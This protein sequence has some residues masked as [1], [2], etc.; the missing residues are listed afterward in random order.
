MIALVLGGGGSKAAFQVGAVKYLYQEQG[1]RPNLI[2]ACSGGSLNGAK[3]AEGGDDAPSRLE[4]IWRGLDKD[5][6]MWLTEPWLATL[7]PHLQKIALEAAAGALE[8]IGGILTFNPIL[9]LAG[10]ATL[11]VTAD[12]LNKLITALQSARSIYNLG[13]IETILRNPA[14]FD[15]NR[16][17]NSNID[18]RLAVVGLESGELRYVLKDGHVEG[19]NGTTVSLADAVLTSAS[20]PFVFPP[21]KIGPETY[22]D[23]GVREM[24]PIKTAVASGA[25]QIYAIPASKAGVRRHGSFDSLNVLD[26]TKRVAA[27][28]MPDE[29]Q[30][31]ETNPDGAGWPG[32][33]T[34]I[35]PRVETYDGLTIH[36]GLI[37]LAIDY[38]WMCARDVV[39]TTT[40]RNLCEQVTDRLLLLRKRILDIEEKGGGSSAG[41]WFRFRGMKRLVAK[42]ATLRMALGGS[43]P[44]GS[45]WWSR[46]E[47]HRRAWVRPMPTP[48]DAFQLRP[49]PEPAFVPAEDPPTVPTAAGLTT[50][51]YGSTVVLGHWL[52]DS[53]L[54]S[55]P[56]AY[57]HSGTSG[58]QRVFGLDESTGN[59][60]WI[61]K[62]PT[63]QPPG[64]RWGQPVQNGDVIRLEHGNTGRNLHSHAGFPS[65]STGQQ[66]V[67]CFGDHGTG[68]SNDDWRIEIEGGGPWGAGKRVRLIHVNTN[69]ALHSHERSFFGHN[70]HEDD[71]IPRPLQEVTAFSSRDDNDLWFMIQAAP[72]PQRSAVFV[73]QSVPA[74]LQA[75][76]RATVQVTL[77][78]TGSATWTSGGA[79]PFRLGSQN[80][81]ENQTWGLSRASLAA[82][83]VAPGAEATFTFEIQ[84]PAVPGTYNF[85]WRMLQH[86][87]EWFGDQTPN[88]AIQVVQ[89]PPQRSATFVRQTVPTRIMAGSSATVQITMRN[90][91]A[92]TWTSAV[93]TPFRL[94]SQN[95]QDNQRWGL[96]RV[97]LPVA[98][99][100]PGAEVTFSFDIQIPMTPGAFGFQWRMLQESVEWFGD[101]TANVTIR[102][103]PEGVG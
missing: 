77:R 99:V 49:Y 79:T 2:A 65:P 74:S 60:N 68:D 94:G 3:L 35:Q 53:N 24:V 85:Q 36:P 52:T 40:D 92:T 21:R 97:A 20:I 95:P 63:A 46:W 43:I 78:N 13:P 12:D 34:L 41:P 44:A 28:I 80:P 18:L 89:P 81:Q 86:T 76:Q 66:E 39:G 57:T 9:F 22:V 88:V 93:G 16:I 102:V 83:T 23:G 51:T 31:N 91:G 90:T 6:D 42:L 59:D 75:G 45:D 38:G 67:T 101:S 61:V 69:S 54:Y 17:R 73:S 64:F 96:S 47:G 62:G 48:W 98:T 4:A 71:P 19:L 70:V 58:Q 8:T 33:V 30:H 27:D 56:W 37:S 29:T 50:A 103:T 1:V 84:A 72:L 82:A 10:I 55:D 100:P 26:I 15:E 87:V 32:S 25:N 11:I 7:E 14:L 5:T